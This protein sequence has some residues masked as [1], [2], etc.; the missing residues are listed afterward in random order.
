MKFYPYEK[1]GG[2]ASFSHVERGQKQFW[3]SFYVVARNLSH[4]EGGGGKSVHPLK[5]GRK[6][7]N[8]VLRGAQKV[9]DPGVL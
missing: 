1:V 5:G 6:K 2:G 3:G 7:F 4:S 9:S 8:L